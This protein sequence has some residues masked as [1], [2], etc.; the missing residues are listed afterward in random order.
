MFA[1]RIYNKPSIQNYRGKHFW[2]MHC[3]KNI[4]IVYSLYQM[5]TWEWLSKVCLVTVKNI[6]YGYNNPLLNKYLINVDELGFL[7]GDVRI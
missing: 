1:R 6:S 5:N 7:G 2:L 4:F 3:F